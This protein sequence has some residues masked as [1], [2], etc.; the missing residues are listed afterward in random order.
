[1][2]NRLITIPLFALALGVAFDYLFVDQA[3][4]VNYPIWIGAFIVGLVFFFPERLATAD[5]RSR[6]FFGGSVLFAVMVF[7]R[8]SDLLTTLNMLASLGLLALGIEAL[9]GKPVR[10]YAVVDYFMTVFLPLKCFPY[11]FTGMEQL[12]ALGA[13]A[14]KRSNLARFLKGLFIALPIVGILIILFSSADLVFRKYVTDLVSFDFSMVTVA[15]FLR[16][17]FVSAAAFAV[18]TYI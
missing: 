11:F 15:Y 3:L 13:A 9:A 7:V 18:C 8:E 4:G 17:G 2:M 5:R 6:F 12:T 16:V 10:R 14:E 1:M